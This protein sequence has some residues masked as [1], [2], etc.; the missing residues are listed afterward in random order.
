[1]AASIAWQ[2]GHHVAS[3]STTGI[4]LSAIAFCASFASMV[5]KSP[6]GCKRTIVKP[7]DTRFSDSLDCEAASVPRAIVSGIEVGFCGNRNLQANKIAVMKM[8]MIFL[9][10]FNFLSIGFQTNMHPGHE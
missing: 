2:G 9:F 8:I 5:C 1:M 10:M 3:N 7:A 4:C 6:L